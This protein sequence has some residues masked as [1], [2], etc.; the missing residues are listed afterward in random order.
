MTC[1]YLTPKPGVRAIVTI[2]DGEITKE[3][4]AA[5]DAIVSAACEYHESEERQT[6]RYTEGRFDEAD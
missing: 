6:G 2:A 5:I 4:L 1:L 3:S